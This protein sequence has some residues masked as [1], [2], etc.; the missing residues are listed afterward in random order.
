MSRRFGTRFGRGRVQAAADRS[1]AAPTISSALRGGVAYGDDA[2]G[3]SVTITGTG[4]S[5]G[6]LTGV[7]F[8]GDAATNLSVTNDTTATC[9]SPAHAAGLVDVVVSGPGGSG[10]LTN[11]YRYLA[12][13]TV[14]AVNNGKTS[15]AVGDTDGGYTVT[16][17]GTGFANDGLSGITIGG[18]AVT[19]VNVTNDTTATGVV[20]AGTIGEKNVVVS[21]PGGTGTLT[22]GW[23]NWD[24]SALTTTLWLRET[25]TTSGSTVTQWTDKSGNSRN[26]TPPATAPNV[27][28]TVNGQPTVNFDTGAKSLTN[29][30]ALSSF[31]ANNA[32]TIYAVVN[33]TT[34]GT[35][36]T[37]DAD[38]AVIGDTGG[39]WALSLHQSTTAV[40]LY[41]WDGSEDNDSQTLAVETWALIEGFHSGGALLTRK[42]N[43]SQSAGTASGNSTSL[44]GT[45]R[46]GQSSTAQNMNGSVA[47]IVLMNSVLD[48]TTA[49]YYRAY[50]M[51]RYNL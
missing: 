13:P 16:F 36:S 30:T 10:T 40:R 45:M 11:G 21:G 28:P 48:A 6:G 34:Y 14:S 22:N 20:P 47:E 1:Y 3:Q 8:G 39:I 5:S 49:G 43:G 7:T 17:T 9:D 4:F 37:G 51:T 26:F 15:A 35:N 18:V 42:N 29:A 19:S 2:G 31:I 27:G 25:R 33:V 32:F 41:N 24:P 50:A 44:A 46:V 38:Q 23:R 12:A